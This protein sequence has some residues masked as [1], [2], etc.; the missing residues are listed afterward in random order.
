MS[1]AAIASGVWHSVTSALGTPRAETASFSPAAGKA[2]PPPPAAAPE[3]H[4]LHDLQ[5]WILAQ[6]PAAAG[7]AADGRA[8]AA[9]AAASAL[10][11]AGP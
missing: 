9:Y 11:R 1:I 2:K 8:R 5:S 6:Q 7:A 3:Q 10:G 4:L